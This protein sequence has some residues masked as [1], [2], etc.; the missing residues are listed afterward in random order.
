MTNNTTA[1]V[2]MIVRAPPASIIAAFVEPAQLTRFWLSAASGPLALGVAVRWEFLVPGAVAQTT[3]TRLEPEAI[4][5]TWDDGSTVEIT[6]EPIDGGTAV[7]LVNAGFQGPADEIVET[8]LGATEGFALVLADLKA[9]LESGASPGIVRD[10]ARLI[11]L[12]T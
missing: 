2:S 9:M 5:W 10:K 11:E 3:A 4:A 8:A 1:R 12:R 7:T 6:L